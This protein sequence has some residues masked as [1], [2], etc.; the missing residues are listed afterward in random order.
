MRILTLIIFLF[1]FQTVSAQT[2]IVTYAGNNGKETFYDV[3][4][5]TDGTFLVCGY[6]DNLDWI[7]ASVQN[8]ELGNTSN[9]HNSLGTNRYGFILHL[10]SDLQQILQVVHF[11]QGAV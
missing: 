10:S 8:I 4:Q 11:P 1:A 6:A 7:N 3:L 2:N 5:I 9:I